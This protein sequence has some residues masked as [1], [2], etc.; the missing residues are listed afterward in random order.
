[1]LEI[2]GDY[3]GLRRSRIPAGPSCYLADSPGVAAAW[4]REW[5]ENGVQVH[6]EAAA[7][8][9]PTER[10]PDSGRLFVK[11][12]ARARWLPGIC[13]TS[14]RRMEQNTACAGQWNAVASAPRAL[15]VRTIV[16]ARKRV[17]Q[18]WPPNSVHSGRG[19]SVS[20]SMY[21]GLG[22]RSR[23]A[24]K[25]SQGDWWRH[26]RATPIGVPSWRGSPIGG[27]AWS[28]KAWNVR[29]SGTDLLR[30]GT[31]AVALSSYPARCRSISAHGVRGQRC[32]A[33]TP[34]HLGHIAGAADPRV[35]YASRRRPPPSRISLQRGTVGAYA[36][37]TVDSFNCQRW[38]GAVGRRVELRRALPRT[39]PP[40]MWP[41]CPQCSPPTARDVGPA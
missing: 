19:G 33:P 36:R 40:G 35:L 23:G 8:V 26:L 15:N 18:P 37:M 2:C 28:G 7:H 21:G 12:A 32:L 31:A 3:A 22:P 29:G 6:L 5:S 16:H 11:A 38:E 20:K 17:M 4:Q 30:R 9:H 39:C 41:W 13:N 14:R 34:L 27:R 1:M 24:P 10:P 25:R